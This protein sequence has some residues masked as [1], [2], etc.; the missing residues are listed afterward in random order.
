MDSL[1]HARVRAEQLQ[2]ELAETQK[3]LEDS[4]QHVRNLEAASRQAQESLVGCIK[5]AE[6]ERDDWK[7][8][9]ARKDALLK[10][11]SEVAEGY[12]RERDE[13]IKSHE[14]S[15]SFS[16]DLQAKEPASGRAREAIPGRGKAPEA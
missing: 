11:A 8:H 13:W 1:K 16:G 10:T 4:R 3:D 6:A 2:A 14:L 15:A 7:E 12:E 9:A 5:R